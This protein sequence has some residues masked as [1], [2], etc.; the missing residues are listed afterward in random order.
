M[1]IWYSPF[2]GYLV[3]LM[4]VFLFGSSWYLLMYWFNELLM[5]TK[6][7]LLNQFPTNWLQKWH[8]DNA[9]G[10]RGG[11]DGFGA[12]L[13]LPLHSV[14]LPSRGLIFRY[15]N[16]L[17]PKLV[18]PQAVMNNE[19]KQMAIISLFYPELY[20]FLTKFYQILSFVPRW[21]AVLNYLFNICALYGWFEWA[22]SIAVLAEF[23]NASV[24]YC[25]AELAL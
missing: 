15:R 22:I 24:V 10:E 25:A 17:P 3:A 21:P 1:T 18:I 14:V 7:L 13:V 2:T 9:T 20:F 23:W 6:W 16:Q 5:L 19:G 4:H 8:D 11:K 12:Q